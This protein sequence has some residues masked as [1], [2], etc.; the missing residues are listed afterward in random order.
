[1]AAGSTGLAGDSGSIKGS[2][3]S[4]GHSDVMGISKEPRCPLGMSILQPSPKLQCDGRHLVK[5]LGDVFS[6][7]Q[8]Q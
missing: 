4:I 8:L 3:E 7:S 1:M 2:P 6:G 5:T